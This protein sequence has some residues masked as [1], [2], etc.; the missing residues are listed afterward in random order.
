MVD[1]YANTPCNQLKAWSANNGMADPTAF[2]SD[3]H[4]NMSDYGT[5]GMPKIAV[6]GCSSHKIFYNENYTAAGIE[7]AINTALLECDMST[8]TIEEDTDVIFNM[9]LSP[10]P[11][12]GE[13]N[14]IYEVSQP[15][16]VAVDVI[17]MTG[18]R[19]L[20]V[21]DGFQQIGQSEIKFDSGLLNDGFY[22][23]RIQSN[24][25]LKI[26]KFTVVR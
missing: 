7:D 25:G 16:D 23:L 6:V 13:V 24:A 8:T 9:S 26:K 22:F 15:S 14:V 19:V 12:Y 11:A 21:A 5:P 1:D 18:E 17:N 20:S 4:I 3:S 10:N 2:F